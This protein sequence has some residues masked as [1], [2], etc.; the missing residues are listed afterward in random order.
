MKNLKTT[1][2]LLAVIIVFGGVMA[3]VNL[4][5]GP[6]IDANNAGAA[7]ERLNAVMPDGDNAFEDITATLKLPE[8]FVNPANAN[9]T[10]NIVAVHKEINN[11]FGYVVEVAWTSE[12]SHGDEP[13]LVLVGI[14]PDG[15]IINV[16]NESYHD[17]D[18]YNIFSKDPAYAPGF[19]GKDSALADIGTVAGSTHSSDS[20]RS[21]VAHAF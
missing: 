1:A 6:I 14:S 21:A 3:L 11:N 8:K 12:D 5:T 17:T 18:A 7:G 13:N 20:F 9:R 2:I 19:V 4:Y 10:A 16:N 15:K